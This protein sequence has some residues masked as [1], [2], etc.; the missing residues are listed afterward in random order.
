VILESTIKENEI[1]AEL[2]RTREALTADAHIM[3]AV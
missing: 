2:G 1:D 3:A